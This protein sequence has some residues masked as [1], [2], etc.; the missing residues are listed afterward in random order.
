MAN[1]ILSHFSVS[2]DLLLPG[3][4]WK[5]EEVEETDSETKVETGAETE[6]AGHFEAMKIYEV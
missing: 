5:E 6:Q 4:Q 3:Q 1:I 2:R